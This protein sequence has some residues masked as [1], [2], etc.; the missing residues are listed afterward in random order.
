MKELRDRVWNET[1]NL[2]ASSVHHAIETCGYIFEE[3]SKKHLQKTEELEVKLKAMN[4][5]LDKIDLG[6][7][8]E[9]GAKKEFIRIKFMGIKNDSPT[10]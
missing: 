6:L 10:R 9:E 3:P 4:K 8:K 1:E 7:I 2:L 5:L